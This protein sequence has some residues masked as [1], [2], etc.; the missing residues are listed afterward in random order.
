ME[1]T[2]TEPLGKEVQ[3]LFV[4]RFFS[5]K[6]FSQTDGDLLQETPQCSGIIGTGESFDSLGLCL[7]ISFVVFRRLDIISGINTLVH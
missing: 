3:L 4:T 2:E 5:S 6:I 1:I 7:V